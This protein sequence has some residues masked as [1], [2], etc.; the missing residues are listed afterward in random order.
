MLGQDKRHCNR[1]CNSA[2]SFLLSV[3]D[4]IA[5]QTLKL[6]LDKKFRVRIHENDPKKFYH[7]VD[8]LA[9]DF[10]LKNITLHRTMQKI[11]FFINLL[12]MLLLSK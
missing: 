8:I 3:K 12:S 7:K 11:L 10:F 9:K 4:V 5:H 6:S 2:S 1:E